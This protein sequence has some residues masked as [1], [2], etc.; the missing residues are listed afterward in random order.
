MLAVGLCFPVF[1][2]VRFV[3]Q[4][5]VIEL[6]FFSLDVAGHYFVPGAL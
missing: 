3:W 4:E 1:S 5:D 6:G 2:A